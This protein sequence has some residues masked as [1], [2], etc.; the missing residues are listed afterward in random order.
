MSL[1]LKVPFSTSEGG[2]TKIAISKVVVGGS[3]AQGT[4]VPGHF[5]IDLVAFSP[6]KYTN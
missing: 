6:S 5:D 4:A 3:V 2:E 1:N